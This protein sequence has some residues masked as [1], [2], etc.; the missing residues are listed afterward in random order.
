MRSLAI[1]LLLVAGAAHADPARQVRLQTAR[2][3]VHV[4][5]PSDYD[6]ESAGVV[7]YVHGFYTTVDRAW[8]DHRLP[9]QFGASG[10]NAVFIACEAPSGSRPK[11][12]WPRLEEL[13]DTVAD[14]LAEALPE[15][16]VIAVGHSGAHRTLAEW[17][18]EDQLDTVV[19]LDAMYDKGPAF[20]DWLDADPDRRLIDAAVLTRKWS[21]PFHAAIPDS[22]RFDELPATGVLEG[23]RASRVV[24]VRSQY[25][26]MALVTDGV[27]LPILLRALRL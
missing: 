6:R 11:V 8:R 12:A 13:L 7:V 21:E 15:G 16:R 27:A 2:G 3:P 18:D 17:L 25:G 24:Y 5:W 10:A 20:R 4:Y 1:A 14:E 26:H 9:E 22:K 23:A 19:L